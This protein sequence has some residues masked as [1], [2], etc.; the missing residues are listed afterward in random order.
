MLTPKD[1]NINFLGYCLGDMRRIFR[2]SRGGAEMMFKNR[3]ENVV[4]VG[5]VLDI[6]LAECRYKFTSVGDKVDGLV[7]NKIFPQ[8]MQGY[9][10]YSSG[11]VA[12]HAYGRNT[13][14]T[15]KRQAAM[16]PCRLSNNR[17]CPCFQADN[18]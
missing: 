13:T 9:G 17:R 5:S 7:L 12:Y 1:L 4:Y 8:G 3:K 16:P 10:Y 14:P 15:L 6:L 2:P 18:D 11:Y